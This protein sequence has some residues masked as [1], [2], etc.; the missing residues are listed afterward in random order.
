MSAS[1]ALIDKKTVRSAVAPV[2]HAFETLYAGIP[3]CPI[4]FWICWATPADAWNR[5]P[6]AITSMSWMVTP[7][8]SSAAMAL[9]DARSIASWSG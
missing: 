7:P 9:V 1:P 3:V 6:A 4:C 5:H 8:S 2:A